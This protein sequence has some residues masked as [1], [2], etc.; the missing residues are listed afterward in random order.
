[1]LGL[2]N[3][4]ADVVEQSGEIESLGIGQD[5]RLASNGKAAVAKAE[6]ALLQLVDG[7]QVMLMNERRVCRGLRHQDER[8]SAEHLAKL[9]L[10]RPAQKIDVLARPRVEKIAKL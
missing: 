5:P 10:S 3:S 6:A 1:M 2:G 9:L 4:F 8:V 7:A